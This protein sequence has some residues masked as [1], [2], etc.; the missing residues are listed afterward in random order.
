M[1]LPELTVGLVVRYEYI[2]T[3]LRQVGR[4]VP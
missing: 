3:R 4:Q 2:G 1:P